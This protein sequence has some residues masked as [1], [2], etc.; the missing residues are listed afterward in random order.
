[1]KKSRE[2]SYKKTPQ[3]TQD[4][5]RL[6]AGGFVL[7]SCEQTYRVGGDAFLL[8]RKAE[9]FFGGRFYADAGNVNADGIGNVLSHL[10]DVRS[11]VGRL[12]KDR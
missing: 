12:G 10:I 2:V 4:R 7:F 3:I 9:L 6:H 11:H 8:A 5:D 1:M